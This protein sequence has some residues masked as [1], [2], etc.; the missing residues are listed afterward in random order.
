MKTTPVASVARSAINVLGPA[1]AVAL[2]SRK[3]WPALAATEAVTRQLAAE[4]GTSTILGN[5][6]GGWWT[7][8][9]VI[10]QSPN[11]VMLTAIVNGNIRG[12][13]FFIAA[14]PMSVSLK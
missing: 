1:A 2:L 14:E 7:S 11:N 6:L 12:Q 4:L 13:F 9:D 5:F 3:Q 8:Q 10:S